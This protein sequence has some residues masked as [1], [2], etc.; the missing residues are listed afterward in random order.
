MKITRQ[1]IAVWLLVFINIPQSYGMSLMG[2]LGMGTANF[3]MPNI[4]TLSMKLQRT[5][6]SAVGGIFGLNSGNDATNYAIGLRYYKIIYDEPQLNFYSFGS[7]AYFTH[8]NSLDPEETLNGHQ[9]DG[10]FGTEFSFQGL[11][12]VG[13][14]FEFGAGFFKYDG[15]SGFRTIGTDIIRSFVHFYL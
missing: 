13:F 5:R 15:D 14:S 12:S 3:L 9:I 7:A 4:S 1:F 2:R 8:Q 6:S 10:G 11:E